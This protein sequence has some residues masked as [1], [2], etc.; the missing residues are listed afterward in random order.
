LEFDANDGARGE[1]VDSGEEAVAQLA[2]IRRKWIRN[3]VSFPR[4]K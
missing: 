1:V 4:M 2:S 3:I